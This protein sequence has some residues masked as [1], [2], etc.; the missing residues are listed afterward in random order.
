MSL[1]A[2]AA[3]KKRRGFTLIEVLVSIAIVSAGLL[4]IAKMQAVTVAELQVSRTRADMADQAQGLAGAMRANRAYWG[5]TAAA[6]PSVSVPA[7]AVDGGFTDN[8]KTLAKPASGSCMAAYCTPANI[9]WDTLAQWVKTFATR[10]PTATAQISC[11]SATGPVTCDIAMQW[12]EHYV[13][14]NRSAAAPGAASSGVGTM[15]V[16]VLP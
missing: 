8:A 14:V 7:N 13:A 6:L 9:A 11:S 4:G 2:L 16:H 5:S 3:P 15:V 1:S 12:H 10:F